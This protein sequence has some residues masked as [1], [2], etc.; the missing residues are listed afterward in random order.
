MQ[1]P[2][3]VQIAVAL[4]AAA[5]LTG[6]LLPEKFTASANVASDGTLQYQYKGTTAF[7]PYFLMKAQ[8]K[9]MS[10]ENDKAMERE[11]Q[12]ATT[13][14]QKL[15]Y[16]G[17]GRF[18]ANVDVK[19]IANK[20]PLETQFFSY[21]KNGDQYEIQ[22][23]KLKRGDMSKLKELSYKPDGVFEV[24]LPVGA[25]VVKHNANDTPGLLSKTYK[26]RIE[27]L[28]TPASITFTLK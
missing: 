13:A 8:G 22:A 16:L 17:D 14:G 23:S 2:K 3:H 15:K 20:R 27:S 25:K 19:I 21:T 11:A 12:K 9:P 6:C 7:G 18:E 10:A 24:K 5:L 4:S 26:W 1:M 28:E